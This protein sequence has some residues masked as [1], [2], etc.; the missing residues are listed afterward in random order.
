VQVNDGTVPE[1]QATIHITKLDQTS[2][3]APGP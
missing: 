1:A 3:T 2:P